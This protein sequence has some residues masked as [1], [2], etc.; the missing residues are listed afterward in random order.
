MIYPE[1][2]YKNI[3]NEKLNIINQN[4]YHNDCVYRNKNVARLFR[5]DRYVV[6]YGVFFK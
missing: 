4:T 3:L 1:G 6:A 2:V 5:M